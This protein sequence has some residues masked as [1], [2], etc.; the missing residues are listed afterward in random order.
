M[1]YQKSRELAIA[2]GYQEIPDSSA[3]M[4]AYFLKNDK[5]WIHN[6]DGLKN[7]LGVV[8]SGELES[9]GY[10][11]DAYFQREDYTNKMADDEM[12]S[13]YLDIHVEEGE[14]IYLSDGMY[15]FPDGSMKEL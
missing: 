10:D 15:L 7:H 3:Y 2:N 11:V 14:P 4:G 6:I 5:K 8:S 9:L 1:D 13:L 12:K